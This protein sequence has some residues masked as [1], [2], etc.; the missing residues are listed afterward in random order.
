MPT[1]TSSHERPAAATT[2]KPR[3]LQIIFNPESEIGFDEAGPVTLIDLD[4]LALLG[5][6][7]MH[8][9][10]QPS[11]RRPCGYMARREA[12]ALA[13]ELGAD[14]EEEAL[15]AI[16][17]VA[18]GAFTLPESGIRVSLLRALAADPD[19]CLLAE[20]ASRCGLSADAALQVELDA[21]VADGLA[22]SEPDGYQVTERG[23]A[24]LVA[25]GRCWIY[26]RRS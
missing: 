4:E 10:K 18:P 20:A 16:G 9:G 2:T 21:L 14:F 8:F 25:P 13:R 12:R 17:D 19:P 22:C 3:R 6:P 23:R 15:C 26:E 11:W 7:L 1:H 24:G 5:K